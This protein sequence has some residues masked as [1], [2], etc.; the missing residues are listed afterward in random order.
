MKTHRPDAIRRR[1]KAAEGGASSQSERWDSP[2]SDGA[3]G[4]LFSKMGVNSL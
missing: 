1:D 4:L 3:V 2:R